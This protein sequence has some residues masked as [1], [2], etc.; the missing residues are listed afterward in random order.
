MNSVADTYRRLGANFAATVGQ[1]P[2]DRW[3][4]QSPCAEWTAR[5]VVAHVVETQ[6]MFEGLVGRTLAAGPAVT[7]DPLAAFVAVR[8]QVQAQ[9]LLAFLGRRSTDPV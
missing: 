2:A 9:R 8:D 1:V 4:S 6:H 7:D 5:D 3:E